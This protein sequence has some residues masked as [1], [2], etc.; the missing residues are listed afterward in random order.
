M[1]VKVTR[2]DLMIDKAEAVISICRDHLA[3]YPFLDEK[4]KNQKSSKERVFLRSFTFCSSYH[5]SQMK[6]WSPDQWSLIAFD[7]CWLQ[8]SKEKAFRRTCFQAFQQRRFCREL[9]C[10]LQFR[11][12]C[13]D[14]FLKQYEFVG[15][16]T[17]T[18]VIE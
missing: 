16:Q 9:W 13:S 14:L 17:Q 12:Y 15:R 10:L 6:L 5:R 4:K 3:Q 1:Y 18:F 8:S 11:E 2:H 7:Y